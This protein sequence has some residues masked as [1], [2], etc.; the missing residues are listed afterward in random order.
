MKEYLEKSFIKVSRKLLEWGWYTDLC[1][2]SLFLHCLLMANWKPGEFEGIHCE[3]G[4]FITSLQSLCKQ[5]GMSVQQVRTALKHLEKTGEIARK[6]TARYTIIT[7]KKYDFYQ[8]IPEPA[9]E[10]EDKSQHP[11]GHHHGQGSGQGD[12]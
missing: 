10:P 3:R 1:T 7:V 8:S 12:E 11:K 2:K 9:P 4:Q 6:D 5:T